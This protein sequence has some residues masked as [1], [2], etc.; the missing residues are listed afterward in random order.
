MATSLTY[1]QKKK[2]NGLKH[3]ETITSRSKDTHVQLYQAFLL[4]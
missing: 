3:T 1:P 2:K 4:L